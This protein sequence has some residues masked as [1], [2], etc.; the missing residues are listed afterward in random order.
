MPLLTSQDQTSRATGTALTYITIGAILTVLS[1][2]SFFFFTTPFEQNRILGYVRAVVLLI[3]VVLLVIG[4]AIGQISRTATKAEPTAEEQALAQ[5]RLQQA[6][7][8]AQ[9]AAH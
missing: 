6:K 1:G 2:T 7:G 8:E 9:G 3:G 5:K 4:L